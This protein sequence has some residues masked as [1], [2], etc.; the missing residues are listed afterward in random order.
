MDENQAPNQEQNEELQNQTPQPYEES[1]NQAPREPQPDRQPPREPQQQWPQAQYQP[2]Q[3]EY[4]Q[5]YQQQQYQQPQYQ[6]PQY[7]EPQQPCSQQRPVIQL[8]T[9]RGLLKYILLSIVTLGI[10]GIVIMTKLSMDINI[11]ASR[12]DGKRTMNFYIMY[13]LFSVLTLGIYTFVWYHK[14]SNRV[15][16][17]MSRR[18]IYYKFNASTYWL[19]SVL[20]SLIIVGPFIYTYKLFKAMNMLCSDFNIAG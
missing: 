1:Q 19:W 8:A 3:Q 18:G 6:P 5:Q 2:P 12:Y 17:E 20:G 4:Q 16:A 15:S 10:Y 11:V 14:L 13:C 9:N 7:P